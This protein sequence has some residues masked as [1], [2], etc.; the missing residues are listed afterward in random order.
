M[1][2]EDSL[3]RIAV[4]LEKL[5]G[6]ETEKRGPGRP[7]KAP[8]TLLVAGEPEE[9]TEAEPPVETAPAPVEAKPAPVKAPKPKAPP[10]EARTYTADEVRSAL[11]AYQK[12][13][14]PEAAR[15]LLKSAGGVDTLRTLPVEK[16]GAV[17]AAAEGA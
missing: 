9:K 14:T 12:R 5:A 17:I 4:A 7:P 6:V 1:S 16:Y 3:S 10:V 13:A 8:R 11:V 15:A 2:I